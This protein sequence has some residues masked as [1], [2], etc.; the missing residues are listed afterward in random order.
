MDIDNVDSTGLAAANCASL[1]VVECSIAKTELAQLQNILV[2]AIDRLMKSFSALDAAT[3]GN[4]TL[5]SNVASAVTALQFQDMANQLIGHVSNRLEQM[6][7]MTTELYAMLERTCSKPGE[8]QSERMP[9]L[10][11]IVAQAQS[12][13]AK[14]V[15]RQSGLDEGEVE[16]F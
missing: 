7:H 14:K 6:E 1:F 2:D 4:Q 16:L 3:A 15:V 8:G 11:A 9:S 5:H 13:M 12:I 10:P